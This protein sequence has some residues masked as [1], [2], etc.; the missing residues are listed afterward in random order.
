MRV[1]GGHRDRS[2][3]DRFC[4]FSMAVVGVALEHPRLQPDRLRRVRGWQRSKLE[5]IE[6]SSVGK[7]VIPF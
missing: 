7:L 2:L 6:C 4:D 1:R 5:M 3:P